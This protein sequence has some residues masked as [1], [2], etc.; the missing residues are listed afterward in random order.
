MDFV[1]AFIFGTIV[2]SF[3][4]VCIIRLPLEESIAFPASHCRLCKAPIAWYDN[5]PLVSFLVLRGRCRACSQKISSQYFWVELVTG[6][7]FILFYVR[8]GL[9]VTGIVYL[10]FS[11]SLLVG[12]LIDLKYRILPDEITCVGTGLALILS[13][14]F[15]V[16]HHAASWN[17]GVVRSFI[18][19]LFGGGFIYFSAKL[20]E[21]FVKKEAMGGGDIKLMALVGALLGVSGALWTIFVSSL[22]GSLIGMYYRLRKGEETLAYGPHLAFAAFLYVLVGP[23]VIRAYMSFLTLVPN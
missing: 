4:N 12:S 16:L 7:L 3:L 20:V 19:L 11:L 14:C 21:I 22:T 8:F 17:E 13:G 5:I 2:G 10:I 23:T 18:G 15:P 1:A 6:C 9:T